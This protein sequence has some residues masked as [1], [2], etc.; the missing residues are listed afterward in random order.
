MR[1]L[2][3]IL[4]TVMA[5]G[6]CKSGS[7]TV[8]G[9]GGETVTQTGNSTT[10]SDA[11]G[12]KVT[13]TDSGQVDVTANGSSATMGA[14]VSEDDLGLPFYPGSVQDPKGSML[15]TVGGEKTAVSTSTS[16][17]D[18][19]KVIAFYKDKVQEPV[20]S[21]SASGDTK[22][23][24]L[25]GKLKDGA[26]VNVTADRKGAGDTHVFVSVKHPKS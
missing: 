25:H 17:D 10:Y 8:A 9:P 15:M 14:S 13:A 7:E 11:Q 2:V 16:E 24:T 12:N 18:P 1:L 5:I 6:G 20:D 22:L 4:L 23:G 19:E 3:L 26:D 21:N